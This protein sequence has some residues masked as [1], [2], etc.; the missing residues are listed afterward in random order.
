M[1]GDV[2]GDKDLD[3]VVANHGPSVIYLNNGSG[4]FGP[5]L[6][7]A[8][9]YPNWT[10]GVALGDMDSDGD[11]DVIVANNDQ[12]D[13]V[14]ENGQIG[15]E[16]LSDDQYHVSLLRPGSTQNANFYSTPVLLGG[17]D[18]VIPI[19]YTIS[20]PEGSY[21]GL[22]RGYYS[23]DGGGHWFEALPETNTSVRD[24]AVNQGYVFRWHAN[25]SG[26]F[27]QS[28]N[29]VFRIEAYPS[30]RPRRNA[31]AGPYQHT[32]VSAQTFP[33][34]ARGTQIR[35]HR[36]SIEQ[37]TGVTSAIVYSQPP[38][39]ERDA[40]PLGGTLR[41]FRTDTNGYLQ[42]RDI[43]TVTHRLVALQPVTL[44][45]S[46]PIS[47]TNLIIAY[48]TSAT[49]TIGGLQ[50]FTITAEGIQSL[51][52]PDIPEDHPLIL[53]NADVALE[54]DASKDTQFQSQLETY[55]K[56]TSELLY[57]WTNGQAA[58]GQVRVFNDAPHQPVKDNFQPWLD[59]HI[60][61]YA[62]NRMRPSAAQGG[63]IS[64]TL[65][66]RSTFTDPT[67]I[68]VTNVITYAAGQVRMGAVWNRYGEASGNLG[69]D[70]A[71]ALAHELGHYLLFLDDNYLGY[72]IHNVDGQQ[73]KVLA[74][75]PSD[76]TQDKPPPCPGAM[77]DPYREAHSEF[78]PGGSDVWAG[79]GCQNTLSNWQTGRA[80]WQTIVTFFPNLH[81]PPDNAPISSV[82]S[83]PN[84]LPLAVTQVDFN[85]VVT[86]TTTLEAPIFY[87]FQQGDEGV[88]A[89]IPGRNARA[90]LYQ[91]DRLID[92]GRPLLDQVQAY[93]ARPGDRLCV[94]EL[95]NSRLGCE[96]IKAG[97]DELQLNYVADWQPEIVVSPV[98]S[99]T[100]NVSITVPITGA[101]QIDDDQLRAR[102]F[103]V[104]DPASEIRPPKLVSTTATA[105]IF[106]VTFDFQEPQEPAL[107]GYVQVWIE[108]SDPLHEI[109]VD[110]A[111]GGNPAHLRSRRAH[112]R[113]RRAHLRSRRAPAISSDGQVI[114]FGEGLDYEDEEWILTLQAATTVPEM[115]SGRTLVGQAYWLIATDNA[116]D[117]TNADPAKPSWISF[118]YFGDDVP[119]GEE[120]FLTV[121][122]RNTSPAACQPRLAPCWQRLETELDTEY[123]I[124]S[125]PTQG[126]GLYALMS[127]MQIPL[128]G[129]GWNMFAYTVQHPQTVPVALASIK[130]AYSVVW[131]YDPDAADPWKAYSP[132]VAGTNFEP[133]IN[134]LKELVFGRG[135][136]IHITSVSDIILHLKSTQDEVVSASHADAGFV[137]PPAIYY[138]KILPSSE[139]TPAPDMAVTAW[140][141]GMLCG[142]SQ[143]R[144]VDGQIIYAVEVAADTGGSAKGCG[145]TG[146]TIVFKVDDVRMVARVYWDNTDVRNVSMSDKFENRQFLPLI[147]L[148][149]RS[150]TTNLNVPLQLFGEER[151]FLP[152]IAR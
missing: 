86:P 32:Y 127:S 9:S 147:A 130:D 70:W 76:S 100:I 27:G 31:I 43:L 55:L 151:C 128:S 6:D 89:Y 39:Q 99:R 57:D 118:G 101:V 19:S 119:P 81:A 72:E 105:K 34:R 141:D 18:P 67:G 142:Q 110:Y 132:K 24:L 111:M 79:S 77:N 109:V 96:E 145:V 117:L 15:S 17:T 135:Y 26:F 126:R 93:G 21:M 78:H 29:V 45:N 84:I 88:G 14:F 63:V 134:D 62:S 30:V 106:S 91:D 59:A 137:S 16:L 37:A 123:N 13:A 2:D 65:S 152:L 25:R 50:A 144:E 92:L 33:F 40:Q 5:G 12:E 146:R 22:I 42:G 139:F 23:L 44:T 47:P 138:G 97:D 108:G 120:Q 10:V 38:E 53:F 131:G 68:Q 103:P 74:I 82:L 113:S 98:T 20:G 107:E 129:A 95:G 8:V 35:V 36:D 148:E 58:L 85:G 133:L 115:P 80:D 122:Y 116:P 83:G 102:L 140:I 3:A 136:W 94:Y 75:I 60:R 150:G 64:D 48:R 4:N 73:R 124:A 52:V 11:L 54:W 49:P 143:T 61:V 69:D 7:F 112:L 51:I 121:Y 125:A 56:R 104:T 90:V 1:L 41:P 149:A 28:D 66:E 71:R 87:L 46:L 114:V